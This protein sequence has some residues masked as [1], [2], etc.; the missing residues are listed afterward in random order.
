MVL[1]RLV[2]N[3]TLYLLHVPVDSAN[4]ITPCGRLFTCLSIGIGARI[5]NLLVDRIKT[6][7]LRFV[8]R[9]LHKRVIHRQVC[10]FILLF[11]AVIWHDSPLYTVVL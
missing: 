9:L 2:L 10:T 6:T 7:I 11:L 1:T 4:L 8:C 3:M 5:G